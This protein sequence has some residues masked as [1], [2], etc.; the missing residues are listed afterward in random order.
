MDTKVSIPAR[1][2]LSDGF[3]EEIISAAESTGGIDTV[4]IE[5]EEVRFEYDA[6][7]KNPVN[8][9]DTLDSLVQ[10]SYSEFISMGPFDCIINHDD[11]ENTKEVR[12]NVPEEAKED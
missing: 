9:G 8:I 10:E 4:Y 5:S 1:E 6:A 12:A 2:T 7:K 11:H 3:I